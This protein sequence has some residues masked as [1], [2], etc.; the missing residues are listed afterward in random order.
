LLPRHFSA[1]NEFVEGNSRRS[2]QH[3]KGVRGSDRCKSSGRRQGTAKNRKYIEK[4][5]HS[6]NSSIEDTVQ[7]NGA[8]QCSDQQQWTD[9]PH[10]LVAYVPEK[11]RIIC[12]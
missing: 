8:D 1:C 9:K 12:T 3:D 7:A 10:K 5:L 4:Q 6:K 11:D 2:V